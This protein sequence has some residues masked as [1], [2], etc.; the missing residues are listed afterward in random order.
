MHPPRPQSASQ[1]YHASSKDELENSPAKIHSA[2]RYFSLLGLTI[3]I[4]FHSAIAINASMSCALSLAPMQDGESQGENGNY[5]VFVVV[6]ILN[7]SVHLWGLWRVWQGGMSASAHA[8][9][10]LLVSSCWPILNLT[11]AF[12][13]SAIHMILKPSSSLKLL[14]LRSLNFYQ[15]RTFHL[16]SA[17]FLLPQ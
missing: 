4:F 9:V 6:D 11:G 5:M 16:F 13:V 7:I 1:G 15:T 2:A 10:I 12:T 3:L 17:L 8:D 14:L